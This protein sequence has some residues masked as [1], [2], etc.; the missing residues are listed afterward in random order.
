MK[1]TWIIALSLLMLPG[2][3]AITGNFSPFK[4]T[5]SLFIPAPK[6]DDAREWTEA[7]LTV[8][9][10][11]EHRVVAIQPAR[12][13]YARQLIGTVEEGHYDITLTGHDARTGESV[14]YDLHAVLVSGEEHVLA[15]EDW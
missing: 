12:E 4:G 3:G 15:L 14:R 10:T 1:W 9:G 5:S 7:T 2:C 11:D 13:P 6:M 8:V